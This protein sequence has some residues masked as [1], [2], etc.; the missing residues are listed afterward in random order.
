MKKT[1]FT[2]A[3]LLLLPFSVLLAVI[4]VKALSNWGVI[5]KEQFLFIGGFFAYF[6]IHVLLYKPLFAH[7]MSHEIT[8][9][10]WA[11]IFGKKVKSLHVSHHSGSVVVDKTN[12]FISLA[13][14]FFPFYT[15]L[16]LIIYFLVQEKFL[17]YVLFFLGASLSFHLC[18]TFYSLQQKQTD[19]KD[20]GSIF[21]L[22]FIFFMN[23]IVLTVLLAVIFPSK[24]NLKLITLDLFENIK[25]FVTILSQ[26]FHN[27]TS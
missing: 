21:S 5:G 17:P 16:I 13:P 3:G 23:L 20:F 24:V 22:S 6:F 26:L 4:L 25:G 2:L 1:I 12:F 15:F 10:L 11:L 18:L 19:F 14:Y 9:M 8:H 7:V 27:R